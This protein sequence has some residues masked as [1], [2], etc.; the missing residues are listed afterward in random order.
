M[1]LE[2]EVLKDVTNFKLECDDNTTAFFDTNCKEMS[3]ESK[4]IESNTDIEPSKKIEL[5]VSNIT[6]KAGTVVKVPVSV[7]D[8]SKGI[9]CAQVKYKFDASALKVKRVVGG[10]LIS[11]QKSYDVFSNSK[12]GWVMTT[13]EALQHK[14]AVVNDGVLLYI[15]FDVLKDVT[16]LKLECDEKNTAFFDTNCKEMSF[17]SKNIESSE[18]LDMKIQSGTIT[19]KAGTVVKVPVSVNNVSTGIYC[20][21]IRYKYDTSALKVKSIQPGELLNPKQGYIFAS[22]SRQ[23]WAMATIEA[24]DYANAIV[25]DGTLMYIE[26]EVLK[27]VTNLKVQCD[28]SNT[29]FF[30]TSCKEIGYIN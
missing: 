20:A 30:S 15:E 24:R 26:F 9:Y 22:N 11:N 21:Q 8:I 1:Y 14:D 27:D 3:F 23:D 25:K 16:N 10:E 13:I 6:A 5:Q 18:K 28:V 17:V 4:N 2:F 29:S 7:K 12:D 19:A